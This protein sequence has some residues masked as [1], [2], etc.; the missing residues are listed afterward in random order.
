MTAALRL[1]TADLRHGAE[2]A[3]TKAVDAELAQC[4]ASAT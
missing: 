2:H 3:R 4:R 1:F